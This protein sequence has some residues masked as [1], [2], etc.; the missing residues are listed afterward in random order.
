MKA[1]Y[2]AGVYINYPCL[3]CGFKMR[4]KTNLQNLSSAD[5]A[6]LECQDCKI[7]RTY[8]VGEIKAIINSN[9]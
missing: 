9:Y 7:E 3:E 6:V 8:T 2:K 5:D 1:T 4:L